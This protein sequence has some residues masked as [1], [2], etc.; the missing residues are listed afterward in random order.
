MTHDVAHQ[1][2]QD[3]TRSTRYWA[4][5]VSVPGIFGDRSQSLW[6][7]G[8]DQENADTAPTTRRSSFSAR[9]QSLLSHSPPIPI[10][11]ASLTIFIEPSGPPSSVM[12][13][14]D[15]D[16]L[17]TLLHT[18]Q[19]PLS[20]ETVL[21][22]LDQVF[23]AL[24]YMHNWIDPLTPQITRL[25]RDIKPGNI[26]QTQRPYCAGGFWGCKD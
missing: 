3:V 16:D 7:A 5:V 11:R 4:G 14:V 9:R 20:E 6:A 2:Q 19:G 26:K 18:H 25:F 21:V 12:D 1:L 8:G 22:W 13:Y 17:R 10:S 24:A 23:D 15:G